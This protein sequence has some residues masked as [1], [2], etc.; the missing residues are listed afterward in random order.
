MP[1]ILTKHHFYPFLNLIT[2]TVYSI[3]YSI[4]ILP[5]PTKADQLNSSSFQIQMS[6]INMGG[7]PTS[8]SSYQLDTTLGQTI[9][10][11]FTSAGY[12]VRAGFQYIHPLTP[13][14]FII[15]SLSINF[16]SL[17]PGTPSTL[18]NTLTVTTGSAYGYSVRGIEDHSLKL[19]GATATIPDTS[20]E[21]ALTCSVTDA[22]PWT[23]GTRYG[24]GYNMSGTDVDTTDFVNSTYYRPFPIQGVDSPALLMNRS[25]VATNSAATVTYKVNVSAGQGAGTYQNNIHFIA[26]PAY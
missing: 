19:L 26:T 3:L 17:V 20:C 4:F 5:A 18:A 2:F 8:S 11:Q 16:G 25:G 22:T 24:F 10:G 12:I 23:S 6:T 7:G 15:S 13:F 21:L 9:Q 14:S 1:K